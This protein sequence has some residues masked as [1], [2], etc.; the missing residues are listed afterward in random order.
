MIK[1]K[2][3][4]SVSLKSNLCLILS[5]FIKFRIL[6]VSSQVKSQYQKK[7]KILLEIKF[8]NW[9]LFKVFILAS[10]ISIWCLKYLKNITKVI[11]NIFSSIIWP[12]QISMKLLLF[13]M[14]D[15]INFNFYLNM[16]TYRFKNEI[17]F[18]TFSLSYNIYWNDMV[19]I[20]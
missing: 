12:Y 20:W 13:G 3:L 16:S 8:K 2:V 4:K 19:I 7:K 17:F 1:K 6:V 10:K 14:L 11:F 9:I 5:F 15:D 18:E